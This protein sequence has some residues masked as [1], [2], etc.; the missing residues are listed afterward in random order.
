MSLQRATP[1]AAVATALQ[2]LIYFISYIVPLF[3]I[4][5][6]YPSTSIS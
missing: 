5:A 3:S 4:R 2:A 6:R 1:L